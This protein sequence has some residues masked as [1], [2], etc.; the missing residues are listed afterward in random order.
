MSTE[1]PTDIVKQTLIDSTRNDAELDIR[2]RYVVRTIPVPTRMKIPLYENGALISAERLAELGLTIRSY[3]RAEV[4][5]QEYAA[6]YAQNPT[7]AARVRQYAALLTAYNL[8]VTATSDQINA[9][10]MAGDQSDAEKTAAAAG[11]LTL[12]H[13]IE[14]NWNEV[15]G[16]GLTAWSV[17]DKLI[18]HLPETSEQSEESDPSDLSDNNAE[19]EV[20]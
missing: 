20:Q 15:S 1:N 17:L 12:I 11:L 7:L 4:E 8:D 13:D 18:R 5:A 6:Y 10:I 19:S 3:T 2:T 9:A 14:I 16:D